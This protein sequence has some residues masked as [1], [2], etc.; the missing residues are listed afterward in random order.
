MDA[1]GRTP[2]PSSSVSRL[3]RR[4]FSRDGDIWTINPDGTGER[5][6]TSGAEH[7]DTAPEWSPDGRELLFT[8]RGNDGPHISRSGADGTETTYVRPGAD[9][10]F[11]GDGEEIA[12][13]DNSERVFVMNRDGSNPGR[14][15]TCTR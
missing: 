10:Q 12:F 11:A 8:R 2:V 14:S 3:A 9:P 4:S 1:R 13:Y 15:S 7:N 6:L 5:R